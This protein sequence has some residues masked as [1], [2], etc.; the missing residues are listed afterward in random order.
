M[1]KFCSIFHEIL[2][3]KQNRAR[4]QREVHC[5][6]ILLQMFFFFFFFFFFILIIQKTQG[7]INALYKI[8]AKY[9]KFSGGK[10]DFSGLAIFSNSGHFDPEQPECY[11]SEA[12]QPCHA[13]YEIWQPWCSGFRELVIWMDFYTRV[14]IKFA[15]NLTKYIY[16]LFPFA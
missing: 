10:V 4:K 2:A 9:I 3:F 15:P 14:D 7:A 8:L 1:T 16:F 13:A 6:L 11:F 12:Q 5:D